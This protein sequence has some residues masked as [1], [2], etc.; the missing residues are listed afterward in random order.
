MWPF[1]VDDNWAIA[2]AEKLAEVNVTVIE[3]RMRRN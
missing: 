2:F 1:V 3:K